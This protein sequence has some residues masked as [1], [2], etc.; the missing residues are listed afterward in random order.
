MTNRVIVRLFLLLTLQTMVGMPPRPITVAVADEWYLSAS[1]S[2]ADPLGL[3]PAYSPGFGFINQIP[4]KIT[5]VNQ[6]K[7]YLDLGYGN[8]AKLLEK[9]PTGGII[10]SKQLTNSKAVSL[11]SILLQRSQNDVVPF[12]GQTLI[13]VIL[14]YTLKTNAGLVAGTFFSYVFGEQQAKSIQPRVLAEVV[15]EGGTLDSVLIGFKDK[16][17]HPYAIH[18]FEYT[19]KVGAENRH[20]ITTACI[21]PVRAT[22]TQMKTLAAANNKIFK[23]QQDG[24]WRKWDITDAKFEDDPLTET[25]RDADFIYFTL[26]NPRDISNIQRI[27]LRGGPWQVKQNGTWLTL[28]SKTEPL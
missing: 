16:D 2:C 28:C 4:L 20:Y 1:F 3:G 18:A 23:L 7:G 17:Q 25:G 12:V 6:E 26:N 14:A 19:V 9:S 15:A 5:N 11:R 24:K 22:V 13:S 27:S 8:F 21:Y 10:E